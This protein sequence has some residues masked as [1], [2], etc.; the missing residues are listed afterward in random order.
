MTLVPHRQD[1]TEL[2]SKILALLIELRDVHGFTWEEI[3]KKIRVASTTISKIS[4]GNKSGGPQLLGA[5]ELLRELTELK[6][7]GLRVNPNVLEEVRVMRRRLEELEKQLRVPYPE[8]VPNPMLL[9]ELPDQVSSA[10]EAQEEREIA[11]LAAKED[12]RPKKHRLPT[13]G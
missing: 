12:P 9:N 8:H 4:K 3:G 2:S 11:E 7:A 13:K 1:K 10:P 6:K 5:L